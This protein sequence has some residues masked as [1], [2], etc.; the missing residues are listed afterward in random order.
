MTT[1]LS[2]PLPRIGTAA[3]APD[4]HQGPKTAGVRRGR[5][6]ILELAVIA[7]ENAVAVDV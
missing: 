5:G 7:V 2:T 1:T 3:G 4:D 6:V